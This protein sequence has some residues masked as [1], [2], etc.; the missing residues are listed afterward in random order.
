[1]RIS[2]NLS[3]TYHAFSFNCDT[4]LLKFNITEQNKMS[5]K[6]LHSN[7]LGAILFYFIGL[8]IYN[9]MAHRKEKE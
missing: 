7:K 6:V 1:M 9:R 4:D 8:C 3:F 2:Y 5:P